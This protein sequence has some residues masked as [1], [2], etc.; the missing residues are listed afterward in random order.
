MDKSST[1]DTRQLAELH[2]RTTAAVAALED[3]RREDSAF[4]NSRERMPDY[5]LWA[6]HLAAELDGVLHAI[7]MTAMNEPL[8]P[9]LAPC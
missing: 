4:I 7:E 8:S 5:I 6:V 2:A 3:F 9:W 1:T